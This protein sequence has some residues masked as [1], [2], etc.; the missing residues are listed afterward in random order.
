M[1]NKIRNV[2]AITMLEKRLK[3][4]Y[5]VL[6]LWIGQSHI[7]DRREFFDE[8]IPYVG[9]ANRRAENEGEIDENENA[10]GTIIY[11]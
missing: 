9:R 3:K 6:Q 10:P 1:E 7:A 4:G 2:K 11:E 8:Q 5:N